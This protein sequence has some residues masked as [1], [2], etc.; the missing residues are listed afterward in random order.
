[1][2]SR[3]NHFGAR[4]NA[5][6]HF[7]GLDMLSSN[8]AEIKFAFHSFG[9]QKIS[10]SQCNLLTVPKFEIGITWGHRNT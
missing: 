2:A 5:L 6:L 4:Q 8:S 3:Q 1:M 10:T 7:V 9:V